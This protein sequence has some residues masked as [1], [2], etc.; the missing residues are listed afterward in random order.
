MRPKKSPT[1][2][3]LSTWR[4]RVE[5]ELKGVDFD[6]ALT[7]RLLSGL[8][9]QP[10]Y[11][12]LPANVETLPGQATCARGFKDDPEHRRVVH[13]TAQRH[14]D[15]SEIGQRLADDIDNG[16]T[17]TW[18]VWEQA[19]DAAQG[20]IPS[21]LG[22]TTMRELV[23][24]L[25]EA[26]PEPFTWILDA[27]PWALP[28]AAQFAA[29]WSARGVSRERLVTH[30]ALDPH[31][32]LATR[33]EV[34]GGI[35]GAFGDVVN[36][37]EAKRTTWPGLRP[38]CVS[39]APYHN[40]GAPEELE[41]A[42]LLGATVDGLRALERSGCSPPEA[43]ELLWWDVPL[44]RDVFVNIA[45]LRALRQMGSRVLQACGA[46]AAPWIH[47]HTSQRTY[48][49]RDPA[50][51]ML[52]ATTQAFAGMAGGV[53]GIRVDPFDAPFGAD[54]DRGRRLARNTLNILAAES[55][56]A[57]VTDP[58]GGSYFVENLTADLA[59]AGWQAFQQ[60]ESQGGLRSC[61][62][63]GVLGQHIDA[64]WEQE[65]RQIVTRRRPLTG[66]SEYAQL[67]IETLP[68]QTAAQPQPSISTVAP[69][70]AKATG[71]GFESCVAAAQAGA[72]L[73]EL[74]RWWT[75]SDTHDTAAPLPLRPESEPFE[76]LRQRAEELTQK[77][78]R[79]QVFLANLGP[80]REHTVRA[81]F[82]E[83]A[84]AAGGI[85]VAQGRG[86]DP[87]PSDEG[88]EALLL[89]FDEAAT[90]LVCLCGSD[91]RYTAWVETVAPSLRTRGA[92]CILLAGRPGTEEARLR[93]AGV[94]DFVHLGCDL[95]R[96]L[97]GILGHAQPFATGTKP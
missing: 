6:H 12:E 79:P 59:E 95:E 49:R 47:G 60:L 9:L 97:N 80:L 58:G 40:A 13:M 17:G 16:A 38:W 78:R 85:G 89:E 21:G 52:R 72:P 27:G 39:A 71:D 96:L 82:V 83:N 53:D 46:S 31:G 1:N 43:V 94:T 73:T 70:N 25:P 54:S 50:V 8:T 48:A 66:V 87:E 42:C 57:T 24:A 11:T 5:Q 67:N 34:V 23:T 55:H 30:I 29:A 20:C 36:L 62:L 4:S 3:P 15:P 93:G 81:T 18:L 64:A 65:R 84:L 90:G 56:L 28:A 32:Q 33:G 7:T 41:L 69:S 19:I 2:T 77:G 61:L 75:R 51:N 45:K 63:Q 44:G 22:A 68:L 10:L 14:P 37:A 74:A 76:T 88:V 86:T 35:G 91:E 92:R 26:A